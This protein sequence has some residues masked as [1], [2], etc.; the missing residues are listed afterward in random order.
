MRRTFRVIATVIPVAALG[1]CVSPTAPA[2]ASTE[3]VSGKVPY[4][5]CGNRDYINPLGDYINPLGDYI[6]PLGSISAAR[7]GE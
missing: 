2:P 5:T 6:N 1:A 7:P 3:C 4:A